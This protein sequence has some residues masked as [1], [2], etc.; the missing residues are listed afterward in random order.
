MHLS[1]HKTWDTYKLRVEKITMT[2]SYKIS[3]TGLRLEDSSYKWNE[4]LYNVIIKH[5]ALK[6]WLRHTLNLQKNCTIFF[7]TYVK[8]NKTVYMYISWN[9]SKI[10]GICETLAAWR[11]SLHV[12]F[13]DIPL[14]LRCLHLS[15]SFKKYFWLQ[16]ILNMKHHHNIQ[17]TIFFFNNSNIMAYQCKISYN[18]SNASIW[19]KY[20]TIKKY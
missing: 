15:I 1:H 12:P 17:K 5:V 14:C 16:H 8:T 9:K 3:F 4:Q 6:Y 19:N 7:N 13:T 18:N 20:F 2:F 11:T 10:G